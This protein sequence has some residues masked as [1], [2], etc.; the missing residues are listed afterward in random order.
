MVFKEQNFQK[1]V[2][3]IFLTTC[4]AALILFCILIFK[5]NTKIATFNASKSKLG[6]DIMV[7][8]D[9][10][11]DSDYFIING[12]A[13]KKGESIKTVNGYVVLYC[14]DTEEYFKLPTQLV[15][16]PDVTETVND[17]TDYS[18][19]GFIARVSKSKLDFNNLGYEICYYYNHNN[20]KE[21]M[22]SGVY[23]GNVKKG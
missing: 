14:I 22:H 10:I 21:L 12:Y 2:I 7:Y 13:Y 5:E 18:N 8:I 16:R 1:R 9:S 20:E 3:L 4:F 11:Q 15:S 17:G 23:M 19:C 6:K